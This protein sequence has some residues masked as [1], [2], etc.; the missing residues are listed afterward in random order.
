[1]DALLAYLKHFK[2][3]NEIIQRVISFYSYL[4]DCRYAK[5][6]EA[7]FDQLPHVLRTQVDVS[8]N[9]QLVER[10]LLFRTMPIDCLV[11][12]VSRLQA[13]IS[14]PD[15]YVMMQG[16]QGDEML[17]I[18]MGAVKVTVL[19]SGV[20]YD[21]RKLAAGDHFGD[22]ALTRPD[23][24]RTA[25]VISLT[26]CDFQSLSRD[27]FLEAIELFPILRKR[28]DQFTAEKQCNATCP[29]RCL[30]AA[31]TSTRDVKKE[32][33]VDNY[34]SPTIMERKISRATTSRISEAVDPSCGSAADE[35]GRGFST[36]I[37]N[38]VFGRRRRNSE[39]CAGT[40]AGDH[41]ANF[42]SMCRSIASLP[43]QL[44]EQNAARAE[45]QT[46]GH[47]SGHDT[48]FSDTESRATTAARPAGSHPRGSFKV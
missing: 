12:I 29:K 30:E 43:G 46:V 23:Q 34:E 40:E 27:D 35:D 32:T 18:K 10:V 45:R 41:R 15:E 38:K 11:E 14:L 28:L 3:P 5:P 33:V 31:A 39:A 19:K 7:M 25:N 26:F 24:R 37:A 17:F 20:E 13:V 42:A 22:T 6:E 21:I 1:M 2:V 8:L 44:R 9:R 4:W 16:D 47:R 36:A 48:S